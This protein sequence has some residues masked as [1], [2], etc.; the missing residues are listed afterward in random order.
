MEKN[1]FENVEL[2][3]PSDPGID[4]EELV[5]FDES[6]TE[7]EQPSKE[8]VQNIS[9][10]AIFNLHN[11]DVGKQEEVRETSS[12]T[13]SASPIYL[14]DDDENPIGCIVK[15]EEE[16]DSRSNMSAE[17]VELNYKHDQFINGGMIDITEEDEIVTGPTSVDSETMIPLNPPDNMEPL[18][19]EQ[20][21]LNEEQFEIVKDEEAS[22]VAE[23]ADGSLGLVNDHG[24][25]QNEEKSGGYCDGIV[26][27]M[28]QK[29]G[30]AEIPAAV[31]LLAS[32][33]E[34][35]ENFIDDA[36][37]Q[38]ALYIQ[39]MKNT[40]AAIKFSKEIEDDIQ[41]EPS[42]DTK[43][44]TQDKIPEK[45]AAE[46]VNQDESKKEADEN[47]PPAETAP[48]LHSE[49]PAVTSVL[50]DSG[51]KSLEL[52][53][54]PKEVLPIETVAA[55]EANLESE[56][57][58]EVVDYKHKVHKVSEFGTMLCD[59][60]K[61]F[62]T[63]NF[64]NVELK[65]ERDRFEEIMKESKKQ[66]AELFVMLGLRKPFDNDQNESEEMLKRNEITKKKLLEGLS[67]SEHSG[68]ESDDTS[69][70]NREI[71][72]RSPHT[73]AVVSS[74]N[75]NESDVETATSELPV[76]EKK[77][78]SESELSESDSGDRNLDKEIAK[79]ID[80][81]SLN[82]AK[83]DR[84]T[85]SS[86]PRTKKLSKKKNKSVLDDIWESSDDENNKSY[87][88]S[89]D[90]RFIFAQFLTQ[91][92]HQ[93]NFRNPFVIL[94]MRKKKCFVVRIWK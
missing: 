5:F 64:V 37:S 77:L 33:N 50:N 89:S 56:E 91:I 85:V 66:F 84:G 32:Y 29:T 45:E 71:Q 7:I 43:L 73:P 79:L 11:W 57:S 26:Q 34:L 28:L 22:S 67:D 38:M 17:T 30:L 61:E 75:N 88:S 72:K 6:D 12:P 24:Y 27:D 76:L 69:N 58:R 65:E 10:R 31:E 19:Y 92:Y 3:N 55:E 90:V 48:D 20:Y 23:N 13:N 81:S 82:H 86:K 62:L 36:D 15:K 46:D 18:N 70:L 8:E 93:F 47:M 54:G 16:D 63:K 4:S 83:P 14:S 25:S 41:Q 52:T 94:A 35:M 78:S 49:L 44:I 9:E 60:A 1:L 42:N 51:L 21:S 74:T 2:V 53:S 39:S 87:S 40:L 80:I 59:K 68:L